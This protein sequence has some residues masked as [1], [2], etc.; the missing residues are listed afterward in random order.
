MAVSFTN[1][2]VNKTKKNSNFLDGKSN[3]YNNV[4]Y[5]LCIGIMFYGKFNKIYLIRDDSFILS[6]RKY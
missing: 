2:K 5:L 1:W 4:Y 6:P 3:V